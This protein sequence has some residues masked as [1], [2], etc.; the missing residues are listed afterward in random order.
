MRKRE[1]F[2]VYKAEK[3]KLRKILNSGLWMF[4]GFRL[5]YGYGCM[6]EC[7]CVDKVSKIVLFGIN[8][9]LFRTNSD[10]ISERTGNINKA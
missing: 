3:R 7:V 1:N 6:G 9:L 8:I 5:G 10:E 2:I 4:W